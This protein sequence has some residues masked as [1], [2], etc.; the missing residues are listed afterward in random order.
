ML[1][2]ETVDIHKRFLS[3]TVK[4][5]GHILFDEHIETSRACFIYEGFDR[6]LHNCRDVLCGRI[7][8]FFGFRY[9]FE[10]LMIIIETN[11]QQKIV[12]ISS[13]W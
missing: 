12:G 11:I 2:T 3:L 5:I 13:R 7:F 6:Y 9:G 8:N 1:G 10:H 4:L